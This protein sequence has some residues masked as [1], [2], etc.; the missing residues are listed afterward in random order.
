[1][2]S[3]IFDIKQD[4][5]EIYASRNILRSLIA[6]YLVGKY[7]NS[8]FGIGWHLLV[9]I[10]MIVAYYVAFSGL[11]VGSDIENFWIYLA[12]GMLPFNFMLTNLTGGATYI[13]SNSAMVKKMYFPRE[14]IIF[15]NIISS[16]IVLLVGYVVLLIIFAFCGFDLN[17]WCV[18]V[19]FLFLIVMG[20]F[21][22][23]YT[24][25]FSSLNV[26]LRDVQHVLASITMLFFFLS[27]LY[28][29]PQDAGGLLGT[30]VW[31]NPFTYYIESIHS[32]IYYGLFPETFITLLSLLLAVTT[33][34]IGLVIF[35]YLKNG[36]AE[37]L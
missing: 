13:T 10:I 27:P 36:F 9:P 29:T 18:L 2:N 23:G 7:K 12:S 24:L 4:I 8:F 14:I 16:F 30:I 20:F 32:L 3:I 21:T 28:F 25:I 15:A 26:Y 1:M 17:I 37:K 5:H 19:S 6:K 11:R 35:R 34:M 22:I 33:F 31:L